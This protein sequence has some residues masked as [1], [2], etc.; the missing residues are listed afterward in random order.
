VFPAKLL[1]GAITCSSP[2]GGWRNSRA[3]WREGRLGLAG[4]AQGPHARGAVAGPWAGG[5]GYASSVS[6][7]AIRHLPAPVS[8]AA[9]RC[10]GWFV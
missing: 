3:P 1:A 10:Q 8:K 9:V 7:S 4:R 5:R 6:S 2:P